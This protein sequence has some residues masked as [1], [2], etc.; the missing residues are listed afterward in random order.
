MKPT[1]RK[2]IEAGTILAKDAS[3][4]VRCTER[5]DGILRVHDEIAKDGKMMERYLLCETCGARNILRMP[6]PKTTS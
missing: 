4:I 2:W 6:S 5:D 1:T 3:A